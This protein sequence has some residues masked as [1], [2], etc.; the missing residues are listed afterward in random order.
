MAVD[1]FFRCDVAGAEA[2]AALRGA[3][4]PLG[5]KAGP[6]THGFHRDIYLDTPDDALAGRGMACRLRIG[7][8]DRRVLNLLI[9]SGGQDEPPQRFEAVV[10]AL[11]PRAALL[12]D[13]EPARRLREIGRASCRERV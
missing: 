3:D 10:D 11:E 1:T 9:G 6:V 8:D 2:L 13:S 4:L 5:L 7:V 12:G